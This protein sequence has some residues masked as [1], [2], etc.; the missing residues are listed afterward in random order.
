MSRFVSSVG[1]RRSDRMDVSLCAGGCSI[2]LRLGGVRA[3]VKEAEIATF[4]GLGYFPV[5]ELPI[6]AGEARRRGLPCRAA[7]PKLFVRN[8]Q[9]NPAGL[10][11]Q[12]D[13]IPGAH[14]RD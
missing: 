2:D 8:V 7:V 10:D 5:E 12:L 11:V 1:P 9:V 6:S 3:G 13:E 14:Q 4:V